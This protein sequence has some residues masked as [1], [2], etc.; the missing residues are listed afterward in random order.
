VIISARAFDPA[1]LVIKH[2]VVHPSRR[3]H[4]ENGWV[5]T[6]QRAYCRVGVD[7]NSPDNMQMAD[8]QLGNDKHEFFVDHER[9]PVRGLCQ[10][11]GSGIRKGRGDLPEII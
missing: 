5:Q 3:R 4:I 2:H 6:L 7:N 9:L 1:T 10:H 8:P 11:V